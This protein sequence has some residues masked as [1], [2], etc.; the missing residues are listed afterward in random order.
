MEHS[1]KEKENI[2]KE[3]SRSS[4]GWIVNDIFGDTVR[5][6]QRGSRGSRQRAYFNLQ[7]KKENSDVVSEASFTASSLNRVK[8]DLP[9]GWHVIEDGPQQISCIRHERWEVNN[10]RGTTELKVSYKMPKETSM[11][12]RAHGCSVNLKKGFGLERLLDDMTVEKQILLAVQFIENSSICFG[13]ELKEDQNVMTILPHVSGVMSLIDDDDLKQ[14]TVFAENCLVLAGSGEICASCSR[15]QKVDVNRRKRKAEE[16]ILHP[17]CNK[18]F[19]TKEE[20][21]CQLK[22]EQLARRNAERREKYWREKFDK[23]AVEVDEEDQE[24]LKEMFK[25]PVGNLPDDMQCLWE[26]QQ[27]I[28]KTK[29]KN[30]Y[31]W[32]PK[33]MQLCIQLYCKHPSVVDTIRSFIRLPSNRT[34][35]YHKNKREQQ[36]GWHRDMVKWCAQSAEKK[37]LKNCDYWGGFVI[38]EMKIEENVEMVVKNGKHRLVG[39]VELGPLHNDMLRL[40]GKKENQL[41]SHV[42]QFIFL[43]DCGFRFPVAQ[44]PSHDC[45][46]TDLFYQFWNGVLMMKEFSF[47]IYWTILDGAEVN[48]KFIKM[49][50]PGYDAVDK[51]FVAFNMHTGGPMVF[52]V[53]CKHNFK[54]IR[55]NVEK[56][57]LSGKPRCLTV[58]GKKILWSHLVEAY[59]F[60]QECTSIHIHEKLKE[61]HFNL[62]PA[63]RMR[64]HLAEEVLD[65]KMHY[66]MKAYRRHITENGKDGS[67]LDSTIKLIEHTSSLIEFFSTSK[68]AIQ[69]KDDTKLQCLD[70]SLAYF[71]K[72]N[73]EVTKPTQFISDKLWFDLQAMIH[74]FKAMVNIKLT[75]FP[76]SIIKAWLVNQDCVEN[77]FCMTRSCNGQNNNP[78][79]RLQESSQNSIRFGTTTVS[80]K[81]N[82]GVSKAH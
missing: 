2:P 16:K 58:D 67:T 80:S 60:D 15:L 65:S 53:D 23:E 12:V 22:R 55:N 54:K 77:H 42:L 75:K 81:C 10:Q 46:P 47:N 26:Q 40:E 30:G 62:D 38:D 19:M 79:Y 72:W 43:S 8:L 17:A 5:L 66:L 6:V 7:R 76:N 28:L 9:N 35:R 3:L 36:P 73:N 69:S 32:H 34:I 24:D 21:E 68:D 39:F 70:R 57:N 14:K 37:N 71:A 20:V 52:M 13:F 18:R 44:F 78:T 27:K 4:L 51:K 33:I 1:L 64:N 82:A 49:H 63:L 74:G 41:A 11:I 59:K 48:R 61:E 29:S 31:R 56:S 50:F 25:Q 45:T